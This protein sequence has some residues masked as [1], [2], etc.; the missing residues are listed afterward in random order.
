MEL[1]FSIAVLDLSLFVYDNGLW[2]AYLLLYIDYILLARNDFRFIQLLISQLD[3]YFKMM[4]LGLLSYFLGLEAHPIVI[5]LYLTQTKYMLDLLQHTSFLH[6]KPANSPATPH[7]PDFTSCL[8]ADHPSYY[9]SI[10][11]A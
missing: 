1:G 11:G 5:G 9:R 10:V 3:Q 8:I 7:A 6:A 2:H 4:D